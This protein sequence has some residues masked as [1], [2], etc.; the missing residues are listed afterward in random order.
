MVEELTTARFLLR[1]FRDPDLGNV[2]KGLSHPEVIKYYGVSY[3]S[4]EATNEQMRWFRELEE[5]ESGGWWIICSAGDQQFLGVAGFNNLSREHRKAEVGFWLLPEF[6]G[7]GILQEVLPVICNYAFTK[8][9]LHR[10]EAYV[11]TEN[12]NS[13]NVLIKQAFTH[14]GTMIDSEVKDGK[15]ISV[16][17]FAKL[18][19]K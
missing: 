6:W 11:E 14:E 3:S 19:S 7:R 5:K 13:A 2:Y 1:K 18:K 16:A 15:F 8:W 10:I 17:L 12:S 4:L 9:N